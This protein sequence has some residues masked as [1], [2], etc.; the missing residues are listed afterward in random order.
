M[1]LFL[2]QAISTSYAEPAR[3][4]GSYAV[5]A[6]NQLQD[7]YWR[8][9][10]G[11]WQ[12]SM[13]WQTANTIESISNLGLQTPSLK[14]AIQ[15]AIASVFEATANTTRGRCNKGVNLTFSGYF[16]DVTAAF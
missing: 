2:L 15:A 14:P 4:Y 9:K 10:Q 13:W 6:F 1:S 16:D 5:Q 3:D 7:H 8:P 12:S 11:L